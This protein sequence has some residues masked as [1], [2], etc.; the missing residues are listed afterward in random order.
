MVFISNDNLTKSL[1]LWQYGYILDQTFLSFCCTSYLILDLFFL[2][3]QIPIKF[4][5]HTF[6][7]NNR[8]RDILL[9]LFNI[10][11]EELVVCILFSINI[12]FLFLLNLNLIGDLH[13]VCRSVYS[14]I[15]IF[16]VWMKLLLWLLYMYLISLL[17]THYHLQIFGF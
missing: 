2:K 13:F 4:S 15:R 3:S 16:N 14:L 12:S 10:V 11:K 8:K 6:N 9:K 5:S 17:L 7:D 1:I